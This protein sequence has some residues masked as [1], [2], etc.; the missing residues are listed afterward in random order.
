MQL[1]IK[2]LSGKIMM[3]NFEPEQTI[4]AVKE[5]IRDK[6]GIHPEQIKLLYSG[7]ILENEKTIEEC[8]LNPNN[9]IHMVLN[10][11]GG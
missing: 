1:K 5:S 2:L 8:K 11:R 6:E 3:M 9:Q 10:L 7:K 4:L